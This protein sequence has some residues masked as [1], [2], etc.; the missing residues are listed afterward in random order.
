MADE[1]RDIIEILEE[2]NP[3]DI[4]K[5][6]SYVQH[7]IHLRAKKYEAY[8][9]MAI[10]CLKSLCSSARSSWDIHSIVIAHC[11]GTVPVGE[12]SVFVAISSDHRAD[13][14]DACKFLIDELKASVPIWKK[15]VYINRE[16]WKENKEFIE[17]MPGLGK[18]SHDQGGDCSGKK[19]KV[20]AHERKSCC[21]TNVKVN[22][23]SADSCR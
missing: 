9:P 18:T 7:A 20:E 6:T 17:R 15:E 23:K 10:R 12:T 1:E 5:Y 13:A 14:L 21:G 16:V 4:N 22:D 3:I 19:K 2:N 11:L 8:V